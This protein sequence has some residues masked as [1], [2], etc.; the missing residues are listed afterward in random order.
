VAQGNLTVNSED[1]YHDELAEM[2]AAQQA[3]VRNLNR[4][5]SDIIAMAQK[6]SSESKFLTSNAIQLSEGATEQATSLEEVSSTLEEMTSNIQQNNQNSLETEK[7]ARYTAQS[8][9]EVITAENKSLECIHEI[10]QKIN[11]INEITFQTNLLA[12]NAAV[13]AARAGEN[14]KGF[15]VVATEVRKLAEKS[16]VAAI[17]IDNI[18]KRCVIQ[19]TES[20]RLMDLLSPEVLKTSQL[21]Q[22]ISLASTEHSSGADQVNNALQQLSQVVQQ[23]ATVAERLSIQAEKLTFQAN[24]LLASVDMFKLK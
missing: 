15:A 1:R 21:V 13:E 24:D 22:E 14:G 16:K 2:L 17:Q 3:M 7:I 12:L 4:L 6:L 23:N 9:D 5:I 8:I 11:I 18:S 10:A 20:K 19:S